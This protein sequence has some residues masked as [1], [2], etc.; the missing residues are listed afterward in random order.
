MVLILVVTVVVTVII[1][2]TV[3]VDVAAEVKLSTDV[4][5]VSSLS[6]LFLL[7]LRSWFSIRL[8]ASP[9]LREEERWQRNK[10]KEEQK[11][12]EEGSAGCHCVAWSH[13][14]VRTLLGSLRPVQSYYH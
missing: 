2:R 3:S 11:R 10:R 13:S 9:I 8:I 4:S 5:A 7:L 14:L 12:K 1:D 6:L